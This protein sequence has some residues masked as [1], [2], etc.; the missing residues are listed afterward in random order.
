M[1]NLHGTVLWTIECW[2]VNRGAAHQHLN[3]KSIF[4]VGLDT[5]KEKVNCSRITI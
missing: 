3:H 5:L 1:V 2:L 4:H